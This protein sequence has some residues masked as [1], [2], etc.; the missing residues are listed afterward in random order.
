MKILS[1]LFLL[2]MMVAF[3][4]LAFGT[5][6]AQEPVTLNLWMFL[7]D[8]GFLPAVAEAFQAQNPHITVQITDVPEG[9]YVTK[10]DT[11]ILA[12][13]PPDIGF[14][15]AQRWMKAGYLLPLDEAM[16]AQGISRDDFNAGAI[17][18]NC[19]MDG[20]TYCLGSFTGG[21]LLFYNKDLFD[22]AGVEY[23]SATEPM[24]MDEYAAI[25]QQLSVPS[26]NVEERIWG[27]TLG[28]AY[29]FDMR[30]FFSE[31]GRTAL[32]FVDD[33]ATIHTFQVLA[34]MYA[35]GSV[36][37]ATDESLVQPT[38][39]LASGQ[40]AMAVTDTV[41]AQ[42]LL[43]ATDIRWGA[44]PPPVEQAGDLPWVYTGSDE[45]A[46]FAGGNH[47]EEAIQFV[48]FYGT[49]GNRLR[50]EVSGDLPLNMKLAEELNWAG[51]SE[52]RQEMLAAIQTSRP[53]LFVPEWFGVI[54]PLSE[55]LNGL[56]IEDGLSAE[57]ALAETAPIVQ[58]NLDLAWES[59]DQIQPAQ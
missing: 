16:A 2:T 44:A 40:L 3:L 19:T 49:E 48:L 20:Q 50:Y 31:D 54:E 7:D 12:G 29:W 41:V 5:V 21:T 55:A 42:P 14:P 33:E 37:T 52:G 47:P 36:M 6:A 51:D 22:A 25:A 23:P 17:S 58:D 10:I 28:G 8:S 11:S 24:T 13:E 53:S 15:Y 35:S 26:D 34:D 1:R 56:M 43:E 30:N 46:A 32:G 27:G 4:S 59:W 39:L 38:D 45:M 18:R 9:E 57:E